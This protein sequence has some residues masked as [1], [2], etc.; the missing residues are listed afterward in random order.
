MNA[1]WVKLVSVVA[2]AVAGT[3]GVACGD[4]DDDDNPGKAGSA[5]TAGSAGKSGSGGGGSGGVGGGGSGGVGGGGAGGAGGVSG[6]GGSGLVLPPTDKVAL[7][8]ALDAGNYLP[9]IKA[10][11]WACNN[12]VQEGK[13]LGETTNKAHNESGTA[14]DEAGWPLG[15]A[16]VKETLNADGEVVAIAYFALKDDGVSWYAASATPVGDPQT[17]GAG[18][19]FNVED[20]VGCG[21]CHSGAGFVKIG[22]LVQRTPE[23]AAPYGY[24]KLDRAPFFANG[25]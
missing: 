21:N 18:R 1:H 14:G 8:T 10:A 22:N 6:A 23:L 9:E 5:G 4:D 20:G 24:S 25:G 19:S 7:K 16:A 15:A 11:K 2:L 12:D 3:L 17:P 13:N